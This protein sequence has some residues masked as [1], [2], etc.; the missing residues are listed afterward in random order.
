MTQMTVE[1]ALKAAGEFGAD[2]VMILCSDSNGDMRI[3]TT[4]TY[5]PDMLWVVSKSQAAILEMDVG[6]EETIQ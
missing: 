6:E 5:A 2:D 1:A 3:F 4:L